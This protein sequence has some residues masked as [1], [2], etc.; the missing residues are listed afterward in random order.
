VLA[1]G[2]AWREPADERLRALGI[3]AFLAESMG[4][5][6]DAGPGPFRALAD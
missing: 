1:A 4:Q 6:R 5:L 2:A 3:P